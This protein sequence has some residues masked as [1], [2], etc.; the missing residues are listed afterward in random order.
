MH[1]VAFDTETF[2]ITAQDTAP[3]IVCVSWACDKRSGLVHHTHARSFLEYLLESDNVTL[4]GHNVAYDMA[5]FLSTWPELTPLVWAKYDK[6]LIKDT[7]VRQKLSDLARGRYRGFRTPAGYFVPLKYDLAS[8]AH[9]HLGVDLDKDEWR[10]RYGELHPYPLA[11]WPEGARRYA[12]LDAESTLGIYQVQA[13]E[14]KE[15]PEGPW[16]FVDEDRQTRAAWW[17]HLVSVYGIVTDPDYLDD[18]EA[19]AQEEVSALEEWLVEEGLVVLERK[20]KKSPLV[21]VVKQKKVTARVKHVYQEL[22][23]EPRLTEKGAKLKKDGLPGWEDCI[24][25]DS[26]A[27]LESGDIVLEALVDYKSAKKTLKAD[28]VAYRR[29]AVYPLHTR[30]ESLAATGRTTSSSQ[31]ITQADGSKLPIGTNIQNIRWN[32]PEHCSKP[33]CRSH[34]IDKHKCLV[35]GSPAQEVLGIRECFVPRKGCVYVSADYDGLE[36]RAL[37]QVCLRLLGH[38][39][40]AEVLN[41]GEDPHL[42]VASNILGISYEECKVNKKRS[43]VHL[44]RQTGKVAN[45]GFPGG[46]GA[47]KLVLFARKAYR[48]R[49]TVA[50]AK[51]LKSVWLQTFP[52]FQEYFRYIE[53]L[54]T[55]PGEFAVEHLFSRRLRSKVFYTVAANSFFQ[56][57]GADATKSAG[58]L[59][60]RACYADPSSPLFGCRCVNYIHDEYILECPIDADFRR[61]NLAARELAR[62]MALGAAPFFPDV[63]ATASPQ[64]MTRWSKK[65]EPAWDRCETPGCDGKVR[66]DK[67]AKCGAQGH[68]VPWKEAA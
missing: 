30:F 38:S 31:V 63:P 45:F 24:C 46:L 13:R 5:C 40:L 61:A 23:K 11:T 47:D 51:E 48:V 43:D 44:A 26:D 9:R 55:T 8:V 17:L 28:I 19:A 49:M 18:L 62:L 37:A 64:I 21:G 65:A 1:V 22:Q 15:F 50:E 35:C 2:L 29:G 58:Y 66:D 68:L 32:Q 57:L 42:Y 6:G 67:C 25:C 16:F 12:I 52:E 39:R 7:I 54:Q 53:R 59:I 20:T 3:P 27:L 60:L 41:A 56:G 4:V 36:L 34:K 10:L 33:E 14:A